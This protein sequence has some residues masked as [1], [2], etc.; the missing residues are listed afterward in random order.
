VISGPAVTRE[1]IPVRVWVSPGNTADQTVIE[2]IKGRPRRLEAG[3]LRG[4]SS[5][6]GSQARGTCATC[7]AAAGHDRARIRDEARLDGKYLITTS[8]AT[9]APEDV[10][11]GHKKLLEAERGFKDLKGTLLMRPVFH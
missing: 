10:T 9:L 1:G 6:R 5:T 7:N 8:D 11:L 4:G 2:S 3:A